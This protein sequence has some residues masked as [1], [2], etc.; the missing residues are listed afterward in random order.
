MPKTKI[1]KSENGRTGGKR[2]TTP[3]FGLL[4]LKVTVLSNDSLPDT[5]PLLASQQG[6]VAEGRGGFP[7]VRSFLD[8]KILVF[9]IFPNSHL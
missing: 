1:L 3:A 7:S 9:G 5:G 8:F 2:K 4:P 6:G